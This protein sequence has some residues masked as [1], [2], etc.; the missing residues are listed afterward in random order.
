ML[1]AWNFVVFQAQSYDLWVYVW[2]DFSK[3]GN[4]VF[5]GKNFE[6]PT[7]NVIEPFGLF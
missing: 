2:G 1:F 6:T 7:Q 4:G 5:V 3:R